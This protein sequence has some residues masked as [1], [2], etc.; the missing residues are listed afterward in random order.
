MRSSIFSFGA[1]FLALFL[2]TT[3]GD[4]PSSSSGETGTD[5]T[6]VDTPDTETPS[7]SP[8]NCQVDGE[9]LDGNQLWNS[10]L[11]L[12]VVI[13]GTASED[14]MVSHRTFEV[15]DGRT[16]EVKF[17]TQLDDNV[18][19]DF[20]YYLADIQ[21]NSVHHFVAIQGHSHLYICDLDN[22][23]ELTKLEPEFFTERPLDDPQ[24]GM[25]QRLE[26]WENYLLGFAE[27]KGPFAYNLND[28]SDIKAILPFADWQNTEDGQYHSLFLMP[29]DDNR[30]QII[31]PAFD[32]E[33]GSF[34]INPLFQEP[35]ALSTNVQRSARDNRFL[36]LRGQGDASKVFPIDLKSRQ[37]VELPQDVA[38][39]GTQE[40]LEWLRRN[41]R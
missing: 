9:V 17:T 10:Q 28:D 6:A 41:V 33:E 15:L 20:P 4:I 31:L 36:V 3:C 32:Y 5:S 12:L 11:D 23:F 21:Y 25:I 19:P 22:N 39:R 1:F 27:D 13:K 2:L 30:Q 38:Q 8:P 24:S 29:S 26:V 35:T 37:L 14:G 16:C 40:I 34:L 7:L 18:S